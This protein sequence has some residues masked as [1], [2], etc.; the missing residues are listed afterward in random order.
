MKNGNP[1][2][3]WF[4][5]TCAAVFALGSVAVADDYAD[6][7][8]TAWM[9][10]PGTGA[11]SGRID[12]DVDQDWFG[13][14]VLPWTAYSLTVST[15]SLW[16][17]AIALVAPDGV[18]GVM[19]T[20]SVGKAV[21]QCIWTNLGPA[22]TWYMKVGGFAEFT[23]GSYSVVIAPTNLPDTDLDGLPDAWE[24]R[25]FGNLGFGPGDDPDRDGISNLQEFYLGTSPADPRSGLFL[26]G[27]WGQGTNRAEVT[28]QA[29]LY[30]AYR[31]MA[32]DSLVPPAWTNVATVI[33]T[34]AG[35][36]EKYLDTLP[37]GS[38]NRYY[39][40]KFEY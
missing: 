26:T 6:G 8:G 40:V 14:H 25:Y 28:W 33:E 7:A 21:S 32:S 17:S 9:V 3:F 38:T 13:F 19:T 23:T 35:G 18:S 16:E 10:T 12:T 39:R 30:G 4:G 36:T 24:M 22:G 11:I 29:V 37:A 34:D 5:L 31:L 2:L 1:Y 15:G 20:S 27:I